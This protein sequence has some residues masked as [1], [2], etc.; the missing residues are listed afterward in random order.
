VFPAA[1]FAPGPVV[2]FGIEMRNVNSTTT[3]WAE[4]LTIP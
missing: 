4:L 3:T 1:L 2:A